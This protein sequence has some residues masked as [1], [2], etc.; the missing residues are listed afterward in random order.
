MSYIKKLI[1]DLFYTTYRLLCYILL[2]GS[3]SMEI[4]HLKNGN[5]HLT[6]LGSTYSDD[7]IFL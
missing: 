3:C 7:V 1:I 2:G 4:S 6:L 5:I